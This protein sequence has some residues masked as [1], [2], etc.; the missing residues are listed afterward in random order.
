MKKKTNKDLEMIIQNLSY[1][2]L[3]RCLLEGCRYSDID[4]KCIYCFRE[5]IETPSA[6]E[7]LEEKLKDLLDKNI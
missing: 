4:N 3:T 5:K 6:M 1:A 7:R 2:L